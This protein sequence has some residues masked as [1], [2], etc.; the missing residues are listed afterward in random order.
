MK[1]L[2]ILALVQTGILLILL[3]KTVIFEEELT[4]AENAEQGP[5][6]NAPIDDRPNDSHVTSDYYPDENQLRTIIRE[7]LATQ[8]TTLR[9]SDSQMPDTIAAN[10]TDEVEYQYQLELV[11]QKMDVYESVGTISDTDMHNLQSEIM[12]LN[13]ADR[14]EALSRLVRAMN[15]GTLKGRL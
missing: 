15:A 7:E 8:L 11:A 6:V 4:V 2:T 13:E 5:L 10:P 3:G 12:A 9:H 14:V 1:T